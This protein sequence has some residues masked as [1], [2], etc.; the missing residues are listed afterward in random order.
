MNGLENLVQEAHNEKV[1]IINYQFNS[2]KI[3]GLYCNGTIALNKNIQTETERSCV[4]AEE[5]GHYYTT[6]GNIL[7]Q[8]KVENRKQEQKA[9][10]WAYDKLVNL[11]GII[12]VY[13][14]GYHSLHEA[15]EYLEV[16]EDFLREALTYYRNKYG[17]SVK[18]GDCIIFFEPSLGVLKLI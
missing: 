1:D 18:S 3:K 15:A 16:T 5:L 14:S 8:S 7:D 9:R 12:K 2:D 4:L 10:A 13:E 17:V 11:Q 6:V